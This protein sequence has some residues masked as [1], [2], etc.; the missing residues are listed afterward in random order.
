MKNKTSRM[1]EKMADLLSDSRYTLSDWKY[2]I[3]YYLTNQESAIAIR[4][5]N[6]ADGINY[7]LDRQGIDIPAEFIV[8]YPE[9]TMVEIDGREYRGH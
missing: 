5:K 6:L 8:A 2:L 4:A 3:P 1:A 9:D 7:Q